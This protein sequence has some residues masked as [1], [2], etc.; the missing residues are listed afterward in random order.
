MFTKREAFSG[1]LLT[2]RIED[3]HRHLGVGARGRPIEGRP[4]SP[5]PLRDH[6]NQ[7]VNADANAVESSSRADAWASSSIGSFG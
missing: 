4:P 5:L 3:Q 1:R 6:F 7:S 2:E